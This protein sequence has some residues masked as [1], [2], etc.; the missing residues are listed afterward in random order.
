MDLEGYGYTATD[1][2]INRLLD[3]CRTLS[4]AG[5]ERAAW[6]WD[7]HEKDPHLMDRLRSGEKEAERAIDSSGRK[8][9]WDNAIRAIL[10][11]TEG[12]KSLVSWKA[13]HGQVGHKAER[14]ALA[15][16]L[17]VT[18]RDLI[19]HE[20]YAIL[21]RPLAEALPWLLPEAPPEPR[22]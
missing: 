7:R 14:A 20:T 19:P 18:A 9:E 16:G 22:R 21:V 11:L 17:A 8:G 3:D 15:A 10:D 4:P 5:I 2:G 6:G 12:R 13:E 1:R